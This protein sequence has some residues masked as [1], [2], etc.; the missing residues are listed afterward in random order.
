M[1]GPVEI[2]GSPLVATGE[3]QSTYF[4]GQAGDV[5]LR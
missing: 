3:V 5:R 2:D 4:N 1:I